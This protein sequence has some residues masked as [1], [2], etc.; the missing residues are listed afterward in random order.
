MTGQKR[1]AKTRATFSNRGRTAGLCSVILLGS[2]AVMV[3]ANWIDK[4][5]SR[6]VIAS[7]G[8]ELYLKASTAKRLSLAFNGLAADWY[9]MRSLQYVGR[10]TLNFQEMHPGQTVSLDALGGFD[11]SVL[12]PLLRLAATLDPQFMAPYEYG[13][14]ILPTFNADEAIALLNYGIEQNPNQWRLYQHLGYVYWQR[15][16]YKKSAEIYAAGGKLPSAP[17][18]M[19]EMGA[20]MLAEGGSIQDARQ[21]YRHLYD[22]SNDEQVR[23]LLLRRLLQVDS[24]AQR[25]LIRRVINDYSTRLKRCPASWKDIAAPLRTL[26]LP[27][28]ANTGAPLDPAGTPY[29]LTRDGCEVDLDPHSQVPYR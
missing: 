7:A 14:M 15:R 23:Q 26:R 2:L 21:M 18:W 19:V 22:E 16:D 24:F 12:P 13:A 28:D 25:D 17:G 1:N 8:E 3:L 4:H 9:W 5:P 20:R 10:K 6:P 29:L 11:L 27:L